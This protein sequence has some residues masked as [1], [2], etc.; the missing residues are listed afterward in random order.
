LCLLPSDSSPAQ[1]I[2]DIALVRRAVSEGWP[3][4][5]ELRARV[6]QECEAILDMRAASPRLLALKLH[7]ARLLVQADAVNVRR[8]R[9]AVAERGQ[10][11]SA[12]VGAL[13]ELLASPEG[14]RALCA[15]T[16]RAM[17]QGAAVRSPGDPRSA[18]P[19]AAE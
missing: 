14:R 6:V 5:P 18:N 3:I 11:V 16:E 12:Q 17:P 13:H 8:E 2:K 4:L 15:L 9:T 7:A 19:E 10:E 1:A